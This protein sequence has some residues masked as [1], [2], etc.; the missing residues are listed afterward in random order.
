MHGAGQPHR[1]R[2]EHP[3]ITKGPADPSKAASCS[4]ATLMGNHA[5]ISAIDNSRKRRAQSGGGVRSGSSSRAASRAAPAAPQGR[6]KLNVQMAAAS[7]TSRKPP[8]SHPTARRR[9]R[10]GAL[11]SPQAAGTG[12]QETLLGRLAGTRPSVK[13]VGRAGSAG[14]AAAR[15]VLCPMVGKRFMRS[16]INS[17]RVV[18]WRWCSCNTQRKEA[19]SSPPH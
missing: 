11:V 9:S 18:L 8:M 1:P 2:G 4:K 17:L 5:R 16:Y 14:A 15:P 7:A 6:C 10:T 13:V 12:L 19:S 3:P